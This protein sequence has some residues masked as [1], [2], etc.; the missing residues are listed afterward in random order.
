M[1][2]NFKVKNPSPSL[3][4]SEGLGWQLGCL[5]G[6]GG[7]VGQARS[8]AEVVGASHAGQPRL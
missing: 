2:Y 7:H 8:E 3:V 5:V 4:E 6:Q 1:N